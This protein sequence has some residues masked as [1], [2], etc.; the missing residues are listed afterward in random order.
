MNSLLLASGIFV[1]TFGILL[2]LA[3]RAIIRIERFTDRIVEKD[4]KFL[5]RR[6]LWGTLLIL[7][8][9]NMIYVWLIR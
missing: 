3:P 4:P 8:G 6:F 5:S 1:G 7:A 2:I 9:I